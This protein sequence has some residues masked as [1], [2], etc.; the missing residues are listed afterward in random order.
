[1]RIRLIAVGT[2]MPDW[3]E[4]GVADYVSRMPRDYAVDVVEVAALTRPKGA[5]LARIK[6]LEGA[7]LL[8]AAGARA[9]IIALDVQGSLLDTTGWAAAM[10][11]WR[12]QD[13]EVCL[14]VGGADG[15]SA[16][17]L[18]RAKARWSLSP[19]TF[20]HGLVRVMVAE[21]LYRAWSVIA[22][23]PYHRA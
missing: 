16:E 10:M 3:V 15:L 11:A 9:R 2:R 6:D 5:D 4:K 12:E 1:M 20:P 17:C 19:L 22:K 18:T 8:R 7:A 21:Q 23:H 14:L 13:E